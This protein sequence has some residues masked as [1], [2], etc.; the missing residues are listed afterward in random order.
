M[1][2]RDRRRDTGVGSG[3]ALRSDVLGYTFGRPGSLHSPKSCLK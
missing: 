2:E 1:L 3:K